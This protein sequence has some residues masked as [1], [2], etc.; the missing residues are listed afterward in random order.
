MKIN[1]KELE[2]LIDNFLKE[3][4]DLIKEDYHKQLN[5]QPSGVN[6]TLSWRYPDTGQECKLNITSLLT[7]VGIPDKPAGNINDAISFI[8]SR[9]LGLNSWMCDIVNIALGV[10]RKSSDS[11]RETG[12]LSLNSY[13]EYY[14]EDDWKTTFKNAGVQNEATFKTKLINKIEKFRNTADIKSVRGA[15]DNI[16]AS[17]FVKSLYDSGILKN[18]LFHLH[19]DKAKGIREIA[20]NIK[21]ST[22]EENFYNN[23][24]DDIITALS[25][26]DALSALKNVG[27]RN[28]TSR[29]ITAALKIIKK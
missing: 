5:E 24:I 13:F 2:L 15:K 12:S 7:K 23:I 14:T 9:F 10:P 27:Y 8:L 6:T 29:D 28:A 21:K 20:T 11:S 16:K 19:T 3:D 25:G 22:S 17:A 1:Q 26:Q 4:F 18:D